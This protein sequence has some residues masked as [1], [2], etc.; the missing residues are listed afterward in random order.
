MADNIV[1]IDGWPV[2]VGTASAFGRLKAAFE[3]AFP[4]TLH[5]YS[6]YRSYADQERIFR[7]RYRPGAYSPFGDYRWWNGIRWGRVSGEGTVA[8]P[9]TSNHGNGRALDIRDSGDDAGVTRAGNARSNWI[10]ANAHRFGFDPA[11]YGFGEPWHIELAGNL[12]PWQGGAPA[13]TDQGALAPADTDGAAVTTPEGDDM[14]TTDHRFYRHQK[15]GRV[16]VVAGGKSVD[17]NEADARKLI[18][19][20]RLNHKLNPDYFL[21]APDFKKPETFFNLDQAG[22]NLLRAVYPPRG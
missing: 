15:D 18:D 8:V 10:R 9:G 19:I 20:Q 1:R 14:A 16:F 17:L 11:G 21:P 13:G 4:V 2:A 3:A 6:G 22:W 12:D 5:V 7:D